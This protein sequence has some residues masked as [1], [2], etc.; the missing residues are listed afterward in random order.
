MRHT[1]PHLRIVASAGSGKTYRLTN[2]YLHLL[3][4]GVDPA[5]IL[6][7]TFTR[8][9][10]G[11]F[12]DAILSKL[13]EAARSADQARRLGD[14][15]GLQLPPERWGEILRDILHRMSN[16]R[17]GTLD[18]FFHEILQGYSVEFGLGPG[19]ELMSPADAEYQKTQLYREGFARRQLRGVDRRAF[20]ESFKQATFGEE[21]KS[22][23]RKLDRFIED[24]HMHFLLEARPEKWGRRQAIWGGSGPWTQE[25]NRPEA[26][27]ALEEE[28][29]L[30]KVSGRVLNGWVKLLDNL[31][32]WQPGDKL[33]ENTL[34]EGAYNA[35]PD[36]RAGNASISYYK[37]EVHFSGDSAKLLADLIGSVFH[38]EL[39]KKLER[40]R[41]LHAVIQAYETLYHQQVRARGNLSFQDILIL[42]SGSGQGLA[43]RLSQHAADEGDAALLDIRFRLDGQ[44]DHWLL[45][46][47]QDTSRLQWSILEDLIDEVVMDPGGER[48]L[49]FVGDAKQAIYSWRGGDPALF[50]RVFQ[51]YN[52]PA[53]DTIVEETLATSWRSGPAIIEMVN[54]V[55]GDMELLRD[56]FSETPDLIPQWESR[57][58]A[59]ETA[60]PERR[61]FACHF[62]VPEEASINAV[63]E[64]LNEIRPV[65]RG[66]T[67]AILVQKNSQ[68]S[69]WTRQLRQ[70]GGHPVLEDRNLKIAE[71]NQLGTAT[72]AL[73]QAAAHPRDNMAW[74]HVLMTPWGEFLRDQGWSRARFTAHAH[75]LL[76]ASG[77][78][79][80]LEHW[81]SLLPETFAQNA[82]NSQRARQ[83]REAAGEFDT[84]GSRDPDAFLQFL[85]GYEIAAGESP[86]CVRI[87]TIHQSKG[88]GFD[89]VFLPELDTGDSQGLTKPRDGLAVCTAADGNVQWILDMPVKTVSEAD[90]ALA[91]FRSEQKTLSALEK[92]CL[93]YVAMTRAKHGLYVLT[94]SDA[95]NLKAPTY[96]KWLKQA[97]PGAN[98]QESDSGL[99]WSA[100]DP[101]WYEQRPAEAAA[102]SVAPHIPAFPGGEPEPSVVKPSSLEGE[103]H[104]LPKFGDHARMATGTWIHQAFEQVSWLQDDPTALLD[105]WIR[106]LPRHSLEPARQAAA[107]VLRCLESEEV[108][109]YFDR[110]RFPGWLLFREQSF[111]WIEGR[112]RMTGQWDRL[113][114]RPGHEAVL[115][116]FKGGPAAEGETWTNE[117]VT[118]RYGSQ[119][120]GYRK[121]IQAGFGIDP[122]HIS[123]TVVFYISAQISVIE[124]NR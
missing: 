117:A 13:A 86:G 102:A 66:L 98:P 53:R 68:V 40:T 101:H 80:F 3:G 27:A 78:S 89:V 39:E 10:A 9:A 67:C 34:A 45:D 21:E 57:W 5:R 123:P 15:I 115:V 94:R 91:G 1:V 100:G 110:D 99:R 38:L 19:F 69:A 56:L 62:E 114:V 23:L 25:I 16:L 46:E 76:A 51:R 26:A 22:L 43:P 24:G 65:E 64:R 42:L 4:L 18:S 82:F 105:A 97:L 118:M 61:D 74:E 111:D 52:A 81:F 58:T 84:G 112:Q 8:K 12:F 87:M 103:P 63:H 104:R 11:E 119:M 29:K 47:F 85:E 32:E 108:K 116:D 109:P 37:E 31:A 55:F 20:A 41:G 28:V 120:E 79:G 30:Q 71:D 92:A 50:D 70:L 93:F 75:E 121:A 36:L 35:L 77:F 95:R 73:V 7:M 113:L 49:F 122:E 17:L 6:A 2:R 44:F 83:L 72:T 106:Q 59:H 90:P 124:T 48:S 54:R 107:T 33:P 14:E 96:P 60:F 88:L